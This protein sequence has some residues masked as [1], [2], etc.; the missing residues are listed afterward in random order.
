MS[1][2]TPPPRIAIVGD[3]CIDE[4]VID[5]QHTLTW[6]SSAAYISH[7]LHRHDGID[8]AIVA[9]YAR[10]FLHC[11]DGLT[12]VDPPRDGASL[13]YENIVAADRRVQYCHGATENVPGALSSAARAA[14][15]AANILF[16]TPLTPLMPHEYVASVIQATSPGCL[17]VL[18]PQGYMRRCDADG[19]VHQ[20]A[21]GRAE[22]LLSLF[23]LVVLSDEDYPDAVRRAQSWQRHAPRTNLVVTQNK[24]GATLVGPD[25]LTHVP[26]RPLT[27]GERVSPVGAGDTF[28]AALALALFTGEPVT[29]AIATAHRAVIISPECAVTGTHSAV[30]PT[31]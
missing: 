28:S 25:G 22:R 27:E 13:R 7:Y 21:L 9:P 12:L 19:L 8:S 17:T 30:T 11:A 1:S 5:G 3:V 24:R 2:S 26:T 10:D 29:E 4:N 15:A 31:P 20:S 18:L 6:G 16:V 23:D 14:I